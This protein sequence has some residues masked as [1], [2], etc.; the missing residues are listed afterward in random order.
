VIGRWEDRPSVRVAGRARSE[1]DLTRRFNQHDASKYSKIS[2][3]SPPPAI[4][5]IDQTK[6]SSEP[7]RE[8]QAWIAELGGVFN[9]TGNGDNLRFT[10]E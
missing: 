9:E 8:H 5:K 10:F 4:C 3:K 7:P 2:R 1:P 6:P